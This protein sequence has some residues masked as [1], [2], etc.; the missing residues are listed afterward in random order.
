M[1]QII[2]TDP[3]KC[4][5][6][7]D[8]IEACESVNDESCIFL[9][10]M[11]DS[12]Q[13]IVCQQCINPSCLKGC[14][15]DAI[16]REGDVVKINQDLCVGCRLC[17]LMCPIGGIT[18]TE[19]EMLKCEQQ[20]M[21]SGADQPACVKA[22]EENCLEVVDVKDIATGL[23]QSFEMDRMVGTSPNRSVSPPGDLPLT[24]EGLCVSCGTCEIVCPT[25]AIKI[26][27]THAEIDK[28]RCIMCGS[29]IAA[30]PI[31][32]PSKGGS[33]WDP[34]TIADI[35][36]TSKAGKYVLRGFGTERRLPNLDDIIILPGQASVAPVDK[37]R[38]ACN[39]KVVLGTRYAENPLELETPVL[40]AGMSFGALSEE[41][42]LAM[43]KGSAL[44]G[45]CANTGEGGMLPREREYADKLMVQYSS[46]R[47]G[48]SADYLNVGDAIEVK[49]GQGAKPGMGGHLLAEKVSPKVAEIR[50]IPIGTDALSP[51]RFLDATKPG[52]LGKHIE[53]IREVTDWQVP[54]VVKLGPG[55]VKDDVQLVAEAGAD[56]I[57]V[58][59]M[60]GG[61]G[62]APEVVIEHT[63]IPTLAA[64]MEAVHGLEEIGMKDTVD[65]I[66]TGG[67]RSGA[68][69]AK[70]MALG[71]D[72]VYIGTGAM[73]AMGCIACR[74]CYTGK[75]PVGIAT[76][77]PLLCERLDIDLA[78]M[79][80]A[81]Y[82]K[83]M[84]EETKMLAQLAGHDDIR[85][86]NPDD[87][88]ALN[89]DTA[90]I[91]GL[92]LTGL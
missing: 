47:F 23:Q 41:C 64:L 74:M 92:R 13:T 53:L 20:C 35:R 19:D 5:G 25:N 65:L 49:I 2:L 80:V 63:G 6:C 50:G 68:D 40:I 61:T 73:I 77:D 38:E 1:K 71:A 30:C 81:N 8:C 67:I 11:T 32:L 88:R 10:K 7:N 9:H 54:I 66:I 91:T 90:Q 59:G 46:G 43:A 31:L 60:E 51:A 29:C 75:C 52:D 36:Y 79:K 45:S 28:N 21:D 89:S 58:D 12:Y 22:C 14:F 83:S 16:Y 33:I 27:G 4:D 86:F 17:M 39:T 24:T 85:K 62:A 76:Q 18:H 55:R 70:S 82:I 42:K 44:V 15:R 57:S 56:V 72:A 78:A 48:V 69:V 34:R 26:V 37:Y 3:A 87:L 84:T